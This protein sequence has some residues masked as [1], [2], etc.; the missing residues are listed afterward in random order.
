MIGRHADVRRSV[1]EHLDGHA[2]HAGDCAEWRISFVKATQAVELAKE[3]VGAVD[4]MNDHEKELATDEHRFTQL[5]NKKERKCYFLRARLLSEFFLLSVQ[6][7][8]HL[9]LDLLSWL[10]GA[11]RVT[12]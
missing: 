3:F 4:E 2:E 5:K 6:I 9:W 11:F 10:I 12:L 8:V 1:L 7:R